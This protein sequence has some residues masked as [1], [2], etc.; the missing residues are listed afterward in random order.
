M[1]PFFSNEQ[2]I[3][4]LQFAAATWVGTPFMP[5]ASVKGHGVSCQKLVGAIYQESGAIARGFKIPEGPM[6]WSH[7][8]TDSL[9]TAFML[10][11]PNFIC[12]AAAGFPLPALPGDL[13]GFRIG[14]SVNHV[15]VLVTTTGKFVHCLRG[16]GVMFSSVK[17][18]AYQSRLEKIWRP[19]NPE[20]GGA[21]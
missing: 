18:A 8:H 7:A 3:A 20:P 11:Q 14:G 12:V 6:D 15:G 21:A 1:N 4:E 9:I 2:R 16:T 19:L 10:L 17:E 5:N 13:L